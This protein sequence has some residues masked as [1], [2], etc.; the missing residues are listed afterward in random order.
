MA[1][2]T[3]NESVG[4]GRTLY[5]GMTKVNILTVNPTNE[6]LEL[7]GYNVKNKDNDPVYFNE[8]TNSRLVKF[9]F[10]TTTKDKNV[11][12]GDVSFFIGNKG[13]P[14]IKSGN[15]QYVDDKGNF[16][17]LPLD[18]SGSPI[19]S[20]VKYFD[21]TTMEEAYSGEEFLISFL[22]SLLDIKKD[23]KCR[24]D[25]IAALY[26]DGDISEIKELLE[27]FNNK[28]SIGVALGVKQSLD[29]EKFYQVVYNKAFER[30]WSKDFDRL[31]KTLDGDIR[32]GYIKDFY[33]YSPYE[34]TVFNKEQLA[35]KVVVNDLPF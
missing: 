3:N 1:F 25:K 19:T 4:E 30:A 12:K 10:N 13:V 7:L 27:T 24:L 6:E 15:V 11:I 26:E 17:W 14:N 20:G 32:D 35:K 33:G 31:Q 29:G 21:I 18:E 16:K 28:R 22:K 8:K 9:V 23:K 2:E 34:L 5:T